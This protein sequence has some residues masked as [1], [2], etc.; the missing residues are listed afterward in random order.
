MSRSNG[1]TPPALR[2]ERILTAFKQTFGASQPAIFGWVLLLATALSWFMTASWELLLLLLDDSY[3][4]GSSTASLVVA[5]LIFPVL[6]TALWRRVSVVVPRVPV[7]IVENECP[8]A[9]AAL[10]MFLSFP[11]KGEP[12]DKLEDISR[13]GSWEQLQ[14]SKFRRDIAG[15]WRM[16]IEAVAHHSRNHVLKNIVVI[17]SQETIEFLALFE[18]VVDRLT[19][20]DVKVLPLPGSKDEGGDREA[21]PQIDGLKYESA[22]KQKDAVEQAY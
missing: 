7:R 18:G 19:D 17:P 16:P 15:S 12:R 6:V 13:N 9:V 8:D 4:S 2:S 1:S 11:G 5:L 21:V 14:G 10:I 20:G 22:K 3:E